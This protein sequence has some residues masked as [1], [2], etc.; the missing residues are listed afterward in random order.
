LSLSVIATFL[1][2]ALGERRWRV[3]ANLREQRGNIFTERLPVGATELGS[4]LDAP[5]FV[6]NVG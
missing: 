6:L 1:L 2:D 3:T 5:R 4:A